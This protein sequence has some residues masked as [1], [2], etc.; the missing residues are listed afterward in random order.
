MKK[1]ACRLEI[2][3]RWTRQRWARDVMARA[4]FP[5]QPSR[6]T[7]QPI[8]RKHIFPVCVVPRSVF[9]IASLVWRGPP[10]CFALLPG[11]IALHPAI[12]IG[13]CAGNGPVGS[14]YTIILLRKILRRCG[15]AASEKQHAQHNGNPFHS[16]ALDCPR[17]NKR[18]RCARS[19][20]G[21]A[22]ERSALAA[23][24]KRRITPG[25]V[26]SPRLARTG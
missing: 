19:I 10:Q 7:D 13:V 5:H 14:A 26:I 18:N 20:A 9:T 23:H 22:D 1:A 12:D 8:R 17:S 25:P 11:I 24:R 2:S 15:D 16:P 6:G 3:W 21:G 4:G